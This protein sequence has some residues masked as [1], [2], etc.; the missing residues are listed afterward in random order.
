[1]LGIKRFLTS[2]FGLGWL[3]I[4]PGTWG[5]LGPVGIFALLYYLGVKPGPMRYAMIIV[6]LLS[7]IICVLCSP[8]SIK[9]AGRK[10]P[11]EVVVDEAAGQ[12]ITLMFILPSAYAMPQVAIAAG[13]SFLLFRLFD[14]IKPYPCK[15]LEKFPAGW[16]ILADDLMAGLYGGIVLLLA[17]VVYLKVSD[18]TPPA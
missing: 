2:S 4:A 14:I 17:Q 12:A 9:A 3:P 7:S 15:L 18:V 11:G 6:A 16:G 10:D 13:G 1:M 8:A 5:S